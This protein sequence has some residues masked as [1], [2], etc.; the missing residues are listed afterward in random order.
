MGDGGPLTYKRSRRGDA[1]VDRAAAHVVGHARPS[2]SVVDFSPFGYDERQ[3]CS[4]GFDL[5]VGSLSRTPWGS[6]PEYHTSGDDLALVR[7]H[8]LADSLA[9]CL[10]IFSVLEDD[11]AYRN[12]SPKGEPQLGRRGLY[13]SLGGVTHT[14]ERELALLWVLN[15]SD[16]EHT[17]LDI[18]DRSGVRFDA[19]ADAAD[20]L[21]A[22]GLLG[23]R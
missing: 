22:V 17:L 23:T 11:A 18:A 12:L 10:R 4:P 5:P 2:G 15:Q 19:I 13:G 6:Y 1:A 14:R 20:A 9:S 21:N 16:G 3:F 7:P 8:A